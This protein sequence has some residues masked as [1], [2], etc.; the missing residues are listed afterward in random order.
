METVIHI[1]KRFTP[2]VS[3]ATLD[4]AHQTVWQYS[5]GDP[6]TG[7]GNAIGYEKSRFSTNILVISETIQDRVILTMADQ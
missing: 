3:H 5:D 6:L 4:I 1:L 7:A 2:L